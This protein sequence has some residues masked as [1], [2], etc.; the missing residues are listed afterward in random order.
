MYPAMTT[1]LGKS[2]ALVILSGDAVNSQIIW[3]ICWQ[4]P[5]RNK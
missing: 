3:V 5:D 4:P 1:S 2:V